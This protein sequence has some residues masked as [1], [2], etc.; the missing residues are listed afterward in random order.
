M[1]SLHFDFDCPQCHTNVHVPFFRDLEAKAIEDY[2][3]LEISAQEKLRAMR[4][5]V[6]NVSL[7]GLIIWWLKGRKLR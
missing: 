1:D 2:D 4:H 6:Y 3:L 5:W 7:S